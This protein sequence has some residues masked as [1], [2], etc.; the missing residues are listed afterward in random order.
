MIG[1]MLAHYRV[2]EK[3]GAGAMGEVYRAHDEQLDR[4]VAIKVL[5]TG[6]FSDPTSRARLLREARAAAALNHP[7]VCTVYEVGDACGQI[8]IAMELIPGQRLDRMIPRDG[9]P[10]DQVRRYGLQIAEAVAHAHDRGIVHRDLKTANTLV[11]PQGRVKVLDFGLAKRVGE[12]LSDATTTSGS[13]T[14]V[15]VVAGTLPYMAPE[16]LSGEAADTRSDVWALGVILHEMAAGARP[17]QGR[18]TLELSSAILHEPP[19]PLPPTVPAGLRLVFQ[20]CLEKAPERRYQRASEVHSAL[21]AD[22]SAAGERTLRLSRASF[23][24]VAV[25]VA[26]VALTVGW[27]AL[28]TSPAPQARIDSLVVLPFDNVSGDPGQDYFVDGMTEAIITDLAK[29]SGLKVIS[30]TSTMR[31]KK[32]AKP[33][34]EI[35]HELGVEA[36]VEG[37]VLRVG[38]RV[39]ITAQ[40]IQGETDTPLWA[41]SYDRDLE[42]VLSLQRD[43]A[44]AITKEIR[45]SLTPEENA[46]A[47]ARMNSEAYDAYLLGRHYVNQ[48]T[49]EGL[50]RAES[51]F[52]SALKL[53]PDFAQAYAALADTHILKEVYANSLPT[54]VHLTAKRL[55]LKALEIDPTLGEAHT[56]LA[57]IAFTLEFDWP[58]AQRR[59]E[60]AIRLSPGYAT[61]HHW[62]GIYLSAMGRFDRAR[63]E[64]ALALALDPMSPIIVTQTAFPLFSAG[65]YQ[66]AMEIYRNAIQRFPDFRMPHTGLARCLVV[67]G[68]YDEALREI[69]LSE[70]GPNEGLLGM[71]YGFLGRTTEARQV[72]ERLTRRSRKAY[73]PAR[74]YTFVYIGLGDNEKAMDWLERAYAERGIFIAWLKTWPLFDPLR[75]EPRFKELLARMQFPN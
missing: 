8:Y 57:W 31:Y 7:H 72:L 17:F 74:E 63:A 64:M 4:D 65:E 53:D 54:A 22:S 15:G 38:N 46:P 2:I 35:V 11:T 59:F 20:R 45:F 50:E 60:E 70:Q 33:L 25:V 34:G 42:D 39:R 16:Q 26:A 28:R 18:T 37:S 1:Q 19:A 10:I 23:A 24:L 67:T 27:W 3:L 44:R 56:S 14:Q 32:T 69:A 40:L 36:A 71:L 58:E 48:R 6:T 68:A 62:F 51:H 29:V 75:N 49:R 13:L 52:E 21:E 41:N 9:M 66:K 5:P 43:L 12:G 73:V 30:R 61:A 47:G 55:A